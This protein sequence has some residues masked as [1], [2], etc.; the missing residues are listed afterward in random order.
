MPLARNGLK[1]CTKCRQQKPLSNFHRRTVAKDKL[2]PHC[3]ACDWKITQLYRKRHS[4]QRKAWKK[5]NPEV[6]RARN[7]VAQAVAAGRL[8]KKPCEVCG[9]TK[10]VQ[11]HHEDYSRALDVRW[12][13]P[14]HHRA[15]HHRA[16]KEKQHR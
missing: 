1:V 10:S 7:A 5:Y 14:R 13:C 4:R 8:Q 9:T 6:Y 2:Q 3:K 11:G 15:I 16:E 12:L